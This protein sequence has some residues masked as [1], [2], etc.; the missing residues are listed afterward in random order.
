[1]AAGEDRFSTRGGLVLSRGRTLHL[2]WVTFRRVSDGA[3]ALVD[4]LCGQ[5]CTD[6]KY[7]IRASTGVGSEE[8]E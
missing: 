8:D 5:G 1:M 6:L 7:D 2:N 3:P 4:W